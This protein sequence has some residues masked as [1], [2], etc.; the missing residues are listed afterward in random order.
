MATQLT[1]SNRPVLKPLN[2]TTTVLNSEVAGTQHV[3]KSAKIRFPDQNSRP[4]AEKVGC[5]AGCSRAV[6]ISDCRRQITIG[7]QRIILPKTGSLHAEW[8]PLEQLPTMFHEV[9]RN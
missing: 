2:K 1:R 9:T 4:R 3:G 8:L 7:E 5:C 6:A